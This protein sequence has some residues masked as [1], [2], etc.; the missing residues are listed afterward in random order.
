MTTLVVT[1]L[2]TELEQ[3]LRYLLSDRCNIA[4]FYPYLLMFNAP[5]GTFTFELI[6][7][8]DTIYSHD[9]DSQDIKDSLPTTNNYIHTF[10]PI[11]P[12]NP[13]QIEKGLYTIKISASGYTANSTSYLA[14]V[15]QYENIQ[16]P[17]EI[18]ANNDSENAFTIR[19]KE[20][21]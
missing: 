20:Y 19:I 5:A 17:T 13:I 3:D 18:G 7:N 10:F 11:I 21:V 8:G 1:D 2:I 12:I 15:Q 14:W 4:G 9:F 16:M 6:K